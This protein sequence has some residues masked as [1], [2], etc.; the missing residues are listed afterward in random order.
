ML[1]SL[2]CGVVE[3][4]EALRTGDL[5]V[6]DRETLQSLHDLVS[7]VFLRII[8]RSLNVI[9]AWLQ[10]AT[11]EE[12]DLINSHLKLPDSAPLDKPEM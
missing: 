2:P 3:L 12:L 9:R 10:Q 8:V 6:V 7:W 4:G 1:H 5:A 11:K